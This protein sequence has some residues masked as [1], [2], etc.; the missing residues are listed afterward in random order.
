[1]AKGSRKRGAASEFDMASAAPFAAT[2][3]VILL[4]IFFYFVFFGTGGCGG[5][6]KPSLL[7]ACSDKLDLAP[8]LNSLQEQHRAAWNE[9]LLPRVEAKPPLDT[10]CS[11]PNLE[12]GLISVTY[13]SV[14]FSVTYQGHVAWSL[15]AWLFLLAGLAALGICAHVLRGGV[16]G[17]RWPSYA[18][19]GAAF[20]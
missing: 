9:D 17:A 5:D 3:I 14:V 6:N 7:F 10:W 18:G 13:K 1:M 11:A 19:V 2:L 12:K 8:L 15:F 4:F 20:A 16:G